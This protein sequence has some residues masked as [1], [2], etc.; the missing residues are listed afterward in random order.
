VTREGCRD[1]GR[2]P[3]PAKLI[4]RG[5]P[6]DPRE[7]PRANPRLFR[8]NLISGRGRRFPTKRSSITLTPTHT[9]WGRRS[10]VIAWPRRTAAA[11]DHPLAEG[12]SLQ[13]ART[14]PV[15]RPDSWKK[16]CW[17]GSRFHHPPHGPR[18]RD[19]SRMD[20][21]A[22]ERGQAA[23]PRGREAL[24]PLVG[25][26]PELQFPR[27]TPNLPAKRDP[28][29]R[30]GR[31]SSPQGNEESAAKQFPRGATSPQIWGAP[32][33]N[34]VP[35]SEPYGRFGPT[36]V[37]GVLRRPRPWAERLK[38]GRP[39]GHGTRR[40]GR[41]ALRRFPPPR[42]SPRT[43]ESGFRGPPLPSPPDDLR[44]VFRAGSGKRPAV[45]ATA[46][47]LDRGARTRRRFPPTRG[48]RRKPVRAGPR[49][50]RE[51][52]VAFVPAPKPSVPPD[53]LSGADEFSTLSLPAR[54]ETAT[55]IKS[56]GWAEG[57][58]RERNPRENRATVSVG[59]DGSRGRTVAG[60]K[61]FFMAIG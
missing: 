17:G 5:P 16:I 24:R 42:F 57:L 23:Q 56:T 30:P 14:A 22:T 2:G 3:P 41:S 48:A 43:G 11:G 59:L 60:P 36:G 13:S 32:A 8:R 33:L 35:E 50:V 6:R 27:Q 31:I 29:V 4:Y 10:G 21:P 12:R 39:P 19:P 54:V 45:R 18:E 49:R 20:E 9:T 53:Q 25:G 51:S 58:A 52:T 55:S 61:A 34:P 40:F 28:D 44:G 38:S 47:P 37:V 46:G 7:R 26:P 1:G 15:M